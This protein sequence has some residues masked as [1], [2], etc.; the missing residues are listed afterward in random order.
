LVCCRNARIWSTGSSTRME[1]LVGPPHSHHL[2]VEPVALGPQCR[3][4]GHPSTERDRGSSLLSASL[5][6]TAAVATRERSNPDPGRH[7]AA[8]YLG[9]AA[10]M[11]L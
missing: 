5:P 2:G 9:S 8:R 4:L 11:V 10:V 3:V 1:P 7:E 6:N